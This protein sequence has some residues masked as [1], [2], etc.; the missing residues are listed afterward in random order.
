MKR[1]EEIRQE[2]SKIAGTHPDWSKND[3]MRMGFYEGAK[4][5][6]EN[7]TYCSV[8]M[9][10]SQSYSKQQLREMGFA[11]DLNGNVLSPNHLA[12]KAAHYVI[13]KACEWLEN[14]I[15]KYIII[16]DY[17]SKVQPKISSSMF[18]DFKKAM[19]L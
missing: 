11:F 17:L 14:N 2:M 5:A 9:V 8:R 18:D 3:C 19:E 1:D 10:G 16:D 12:K 6:D 4:W 15:N 13:D 7:P